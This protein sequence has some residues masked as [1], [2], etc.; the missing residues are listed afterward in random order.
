MKGDQTFVD[1]NLASPAMANW[2]LTYSI[3]LLFAFPLREGKDRYFKG[4][5]KFPG[6][7]LKY[8]NFAQFRNHTLKTTVVMETRTV[9][10]DEECLLSCSES[11]NCRSL[12][13]NTTPDGQGRHLCQILDTD[14]FV[15]HFDFVVSS[16]FHHF[17]CTVSSLSSRHFYIKR[18][19]IIIEILILQKLKMRCKEKALLD[20]RDRSESKYFKFNSEPGSS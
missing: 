19:S 15:S 16:E 9:M 6:A 7:I 17:S 10:S 1:L 2:Y 8:A 14:K 20:L 18:Y 3:F 12:N 11:P 13:F 5:I 4:T